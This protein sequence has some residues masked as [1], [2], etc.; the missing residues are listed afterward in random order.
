[1]DTLEIVPQRFIGLD[2]H[3]HYF[4]ATGVNPDKEQ[5]L[6][7]QRVPNARL[8][9]WAER[10]LCPTDAV[11]LE[12]TT[13]T[14]KV[15]DTLEPFT[16]SVTVA[17]PPHVHLITRAQVMTDKKAALILAQLHAAGLLP[18]VAG[19]VFQEVIDVLA[20]V[21][22]LRVASAPGRLTDF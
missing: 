2:I 19:A 15:V 9:A 5:I 18:P 7:P 21:N 3:K 6:G 20:V 17:H 8:E 10:E 12:M 22:A 4:V 1:M 16:H 14:W 11:V 13:N